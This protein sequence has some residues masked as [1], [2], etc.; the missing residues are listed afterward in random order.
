MHST[1]TALWIKARQAE[2]LA[3]AR[4]AHLIGSASRR[5]RRRQPGL[6]GLGRRAIGLRNTARRNPVPGPG[7]TGDHGAGSRADIGFRGTGL[8]RATGRALIHLGILIAG[9]TPRATRI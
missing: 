6:P 1:L 4:H 2:L 8:R 7:D 5:A 9:E 3:E